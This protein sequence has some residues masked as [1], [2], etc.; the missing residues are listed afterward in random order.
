MEHLGEILGLVKAGDKGSPYLFI[1]V[2][3]ALGRSVK[4]LAT[5]G[6]LKGISLA[7]TLPSE[8]IEHFVDDTFFFGESLI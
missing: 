6:G 7:T 3:E 2:V 4:K 8:V 1:M 5:S